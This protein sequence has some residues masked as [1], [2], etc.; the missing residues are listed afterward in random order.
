MA[1]TTDTSARYKV[2]QVAGND[3]ITGEPL[4]LI[5]CGRW[6]PA[7]NIMVRVHDW[8]EHE[9]VHTNDTNVYYD[10][11]L[12]LFFRSRI[13]GKLYLGDPALN[14][15]LG[16]EAEDEVPPAMFDGKRFNNGYGY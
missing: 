6:P 11:V 12:T 8:D 14:I 13:T 4:M 10:S 16:I 15:C 3:Y 7:S 1:T 9:V 5:R 2:Y